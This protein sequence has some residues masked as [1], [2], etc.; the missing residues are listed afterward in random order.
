M[1]VV[2]WMEIRLSR[3]LH[4]IFYDVFGSDIVIPCGSGCLATRRMPFCQHYNL[5][6]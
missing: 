5:V 2:L 6:K 4:Q 1:V 3:I